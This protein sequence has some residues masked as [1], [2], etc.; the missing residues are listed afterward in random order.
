MTALLAILAA[1]SHQSGR[2]AEAPA[3]AAARARQD[4]VKTMVMEYKRTQMVARGGESEGQVGPLKPKN[5]VPDKE[6]TLESTNLL[7]IDGVKVRIEENHPMWSMP[8]GTFL[9]TEQVALSDGTIAKS[10]FARGLRPG[11]DPMGYILRDREVPGVKSVGLAPI[12]LTVRGLQPSLNPLPLGDMRPSGL[13]LPIDKVPCEEYLMEYGNNSVV[14]CWLDPGKGYAVRRIRTSQA[15][16]LVVQTDVTSYRHEAWG[17]IPDSWV[18]NQFSATGTTL[19][20]DRVRIIALRLNEPQPS[21]RFEI[22]FPPRTLVGDGRDGKLYNVQ[23]DGSMR[24]YSPA[25]GKQS[26]SV[27]QPGAPWYQRHKWLILGI[28]VILALAGS[29]Y[30]MRGRLRRRA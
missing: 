20:S 26:G 16:K 7:V 11:G 12:M 21:T 4:A 15:G 19:K 10:L 3:E 14:N 8:D 25:T 27:P 24:E 18:C 22:Q 30:G 17:W 29:L 28:V 9:Q 1:N 13:T 5:A 2:A 6:M 23:P